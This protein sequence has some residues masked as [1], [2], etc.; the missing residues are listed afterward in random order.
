MQIAGFHNL[1]HYLYPFKFE[2]NED[3]QSFDLYI[4]LYEQS[5]LIVPKLY[6]F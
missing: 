6:P 1:S 4:V 5:D 3:F 2:A